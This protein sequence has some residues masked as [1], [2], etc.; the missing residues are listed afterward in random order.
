LLENLKCQNIQLNAKDLAYLDQTFHEGA[1]AGD[2]Y[3]EFITDI[4]R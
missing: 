4:V 3:P 2:R 1:I